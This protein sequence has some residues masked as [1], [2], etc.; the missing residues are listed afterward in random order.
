MGPSGAEQKG[1][2]PRRGDQ[3]RR[4]T[5]GVLGEV[6]ASDS[7]K[8]IL[9][10]RWPTIP[11]AYHTREYSPDQFAKRWELTG[12]HLRQFLPSKYA[13]GIIGVLMLFFFIFVLVKLKW[14]SY[15][16]Y[17]V[18]KILTA[19]RMAPL[20]NAETLYQKYGAEAAAQCAAGADAYLRTIVG[21]HYKWN[22]T[23]TA[24]NRF[25]GYRASVAVPGVLTMVSDEAGFVN[26]AGELHR[27]EITCE[28]DTRREAVV[29]YS[30][31]TIGP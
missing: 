14:S 9:T 8:G 7:R 23:A 28:Y 22:E 26:D 10:V 16:A 1:A 20:D 21:N 18:S 12:V 5:D 19:D 31:Q 4:K 17:D 24:G 27:V 13:P 6:Y 3:V 15:T 2:V 30:V 29:H 25:A 11:G